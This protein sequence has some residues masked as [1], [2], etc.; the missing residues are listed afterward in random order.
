[1]Y[2]RK[3]WERDCIF[4]AK[5]FEEIEESIYYE[6]LEVLPPKSVK[7][8][9]GIEDYYGK[10]NVCEA[11]CHDEN[12]RPLHQCFGKKDGKY[13]YLGLKA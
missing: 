1:M 9:K 5:D 13:Y 8:T 11:M 10:F 7:D 2:T 3:D 6:M 12:G 4:S